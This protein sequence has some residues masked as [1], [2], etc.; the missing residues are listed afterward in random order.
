MGRIGRKATTLLVAYV[1]WVTL[2]A[3]DLGG[4]L[5]DT[6]VTVL[7]PIPLAMVLLSIDDPTSRPANWARVLS[8]AL[9]PGIAAGFALGLALRIAM[10]LVALAVGVPTRFTVAGT[11]TILFI[12]AALGAAYGGLLSAVWRSIPGFRRAPGLMGGTALALWFWY[13]FFMAAADDLSGL[14][15]MPLILLFTT[16]LSSTWI[17]YGLLFATLMRRRSPFPNPMV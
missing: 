14:L 11:L 1:A 10:R 7:G 3:A 15:A 2:L 4:E 8:R 6:L 16:L 12:F 13:P 17:G 5:V 9:V